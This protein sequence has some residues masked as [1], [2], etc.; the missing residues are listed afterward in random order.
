MVYR[1]SALH[2]NWTFL[3]ICQTLFALHVCVRQWKIVMFDPTES[4]EE[5]PRTEK[6]CVLLVLKRCTKSLY[7]LQMT[8]QWGWSGVRERTC[9]LTQWRYP[10]ALSNSLQLNMFVLTIVLVIWHTQYM[11]LKT[12]S[13]TIEADVRPIMVPLLQGTIS[14]TIKITIK[15]LYLIKY[16]LMKKC[17]RNSLEKNFP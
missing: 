10:A 6:Y 16:Y 7:L 2:K 5:I 15:C 8:P 12:L 4:V 11:T 14:Y 17:F 3:I 13:C 1:I 9:Q